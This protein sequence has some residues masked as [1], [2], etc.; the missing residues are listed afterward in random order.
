MPTS[1][2]ASRPAGCVALPVSAS[3]LAVAL[4]LA[5]RGIAVPLS[6]AATDGRLEPPG[7]PIGVGP[8]GPALSEPGLPDQARRRESPGEWHASR[9]DGE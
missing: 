9:G 6:R 1:A 5:G 2:L 8:T 7:V 4:G 3:T